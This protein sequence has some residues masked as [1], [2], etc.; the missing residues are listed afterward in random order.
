M[1]RTSAMSG[2]F[3]TV[4]T[5]GASSVA[6]MSLRTEFFAPRTVTSPCREEGPSMTKT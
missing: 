6:A 2:T 4:E 5:P 1:M 3:E